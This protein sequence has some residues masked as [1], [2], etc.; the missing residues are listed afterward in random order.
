MSESY[1]K[2]IKQKLE[3]LQ[4]IDCY[5]AGATPETVAKQLGVST[6]QIIKLD[7]N[8]NLFMP[9]VKQAKAG[10]RVG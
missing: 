8:E 5:S 10:E 3:K 9:R 6:K 7:F 4:A 2:W 1:K